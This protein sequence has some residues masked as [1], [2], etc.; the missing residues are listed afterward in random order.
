MAKQ[1][2]PSEFSFDA[3]FEVLSTDL[4]TAA[5]RLSDRLAQIEDR[6]CDLPGRVEGK[7]TD[8]AGYGV[9][10]VRDKGEWGLF[11]LEDDRTAMGKALASPHFSMKKDST[12]G[13]SR[14]PVSE[15]SIS[16][17]ARVAQLLPALVRQMVER[18][19]AVSAAVASGNKSLDAVDKALFGKGGL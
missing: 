15:I 5:S 2:S 9:E 13:W 1:E 14:W 17:K 18:H 16:R 3:A 12:D 6:L 19:A 7:V 11:Y 8:S 4:H 10:F